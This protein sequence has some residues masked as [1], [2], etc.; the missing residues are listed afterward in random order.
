MLQKPTKI[1]LRELPLPVRQ[2]G[3]PVRIDVNLSLRE[4]AALRR[5]RLVRQ[6]LL[7]LIRLSFVR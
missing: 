5:L 6:R 4:P 3:R 7:A 2:D 1:D